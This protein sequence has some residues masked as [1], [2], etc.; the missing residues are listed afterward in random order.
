MTKCKITAVKDADYGQLG[1]TAEVTW[2]DGKK[3]TMTMH[4]GLSRPFK[5]SDVKNALIGEIRRKHK[6]KI[7]EK[8]SE[9]A[10]AAFV[11][12][13]IEIEDGEW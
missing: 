9:N 1:L 3:T 4:V 10:A 12:E 5:L 7:E 11:N 2:P 8:Q 13:T 6:T